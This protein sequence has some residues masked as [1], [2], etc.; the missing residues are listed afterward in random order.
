[1]LPS[2]HIPLYLLLLLFFLS[3]CSIQKRTYRKGYY[4]DWKKNNIDVQTTGTKKT[5]TTKETLPVQDEIQNP[6]L[7][8]FND[9]QEIPTEILQSN[10]KNTKPFIGK[11]VL[12]KEETCND[13]IELSSGAKMIVTILEVNVSVIKYKKCNHLNGP[14]YEIS[15]TKVRAITYDGGLKQ[16]FKPSASADYSSQTK[17]P[18]LKKDPKYHPLAIASF[19][20]SLISFLII[21]AFITAP[22][23]VIFGIVALKKIN[24]SSGVYKGE[25]FASLGIFFGILGCLLAAWLIHVLLNFS[26]FLF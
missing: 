26:W 25:I 4:I 10:N 7:L 5:I 8:C 12:N 20:C 2:K 3:A 24:E 14:L 23:A 21:P 22:L 13:T 6:Q 18:A 17:Q 9:K 15:K 1:M 19:V 16:T 11:K